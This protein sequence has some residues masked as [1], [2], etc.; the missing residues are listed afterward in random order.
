MLPYAA[1]LVWLIPAASSLLVPLFARINNKARHYFALTVSLIAMILAFSMVPDVYYHSIEACDEVFP[2][3]A[4]LGVE[5]G[6]LIDP[7]SV[8]LA[9]LVTFFGFIIVL[10]SLGY[11]A[12]EE[13][14]TRYY[15]FI[16]LFIGSMT[17]LVLSDNLLQLFIFWEM[18]GLC[19]YALVSFWYKSPESVRSGVKVFLMT[20]VGDV[21]LLAGI[22]LLYTYVGSF[23]YSQI[24]SNIHAVPL[25][26][27]TAAAF[28]LLGGAIAKSA[29]LPLHTWLYSAMEAPTS[30]S[31]L[32]HSA[33]MVKAGVYLLAR[34]LLLLGS[35]A[36]LIPMWLP[37]ILWVGVIT[38]FAAATLA[39]S[40][41]D[42]KGVA[43][44]S[45]ISQIGFM[46][47]ALGAAG[48]AAGIGWFAGVLHL[49]S[50]AFF[51]GLDFLLIGGIVHAVKTRDMRLMGGLRSAMPVTFTLS[52]IVLLSKAGL[53]P[54]ISF[55]SKELVFSSVME[56]GNL[57]A[58]IVLYGSSAF[59]F[60]YTLR[61]IMLVY[62]REKSEYV[63]KLHVHEAPRIMLFSAAVLAVLC[64]ASGLFAGFFPDFMHVDVE[65]GLSEI[66]SCSTLILLGILAL[67]GIPVYFAYHKTPSMLEGLRKTLHPIAYLLDH[68]YFFDSFYEGIIVK[69]ALI[70][71]RGL[72]RL[73]NSVFM[74]MP[75]IISG[76]VVKL[77][78]G[79]YQYL[80]ILADRLL[81]LAAHRTLASASKIK[82]A[83]SSS[84][85]V[86][87][88]AVIIGF[89][90]LILL[91]LACV[92]VM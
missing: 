69:G 20:R 72:R 85:N 68:G 3:V 71:S 63:S 76:A 4:P 45:T 13:G 35:T 38:A 1:W 66:L 8:L 17:G 9:C 14:L 7:L 21:C 77:A 28:L 25:P 26:V 41:P 49:I 58:A 61:V 12:G 60:A 92:G 64:V 74:Q 87:I 2:W 67:G 59:T 56:S 22:C 57:Y 65:I 46:F 19:S 37:T 62:L 52:L 16:L 15:F 36:M 70:F 44:Y 86:Y 30:V 83:G 40:T 29:Q 80:D 39:L 78:V 73:E 31:A 10:Y 79:V 54:M 55:F 18:V 82:H 32:L 90:I 5:A 47:A 24:V 88:A 75:Y 91:L 53:P 23:S 27:L 84:L 48:S 51:Q 34:L 11:M 81:N 33:T 6:V 89:I 42:I 50:H 43:A